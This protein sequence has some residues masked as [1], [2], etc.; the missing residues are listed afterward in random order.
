[1]T[2]IA[3]PFADDNAAVPDTPEHEQLALEALEARAVPIEIA[4]AAGV[5]AV[6]DAQSEHRSFAPL[7][8]V[9]FS[10]RDPESGEPM[11]YMDNGEEKP[12]LRGRYLKPG[13]FKDWVPDAKERRYSQPKGSPV[14][15]YFATGGIIDWR[16]LFSNPATPIVIVEGEFKALAA[17]ALGIP[18]VALGG[19]HSIHN[20]DDHEFLADLRRINLQ[21]RTVI[22]CFDSDA[23]ENPQVLS[24]ERRLTRE[25]RKCGSTVKIARLEPDIAGNKVGLD[26]FIA[27]L[28]GDRDAVFRQVRDMLLNAP[29]AGAL[30]IEV[31]DRR[32]IENLE[33]L[34]EALIESELPVFQQ[35]GRVVHIVNAAEVTDTEEIKRAADSPVIREASALTIQQFG[36]HVTEFVKWNE[37]KKTYLPTVCPRSLAE[38]YL[39]KVGGWGLPGLHGIVEA[40]TIRPGG[41]ILQTPGYDA[42]SGLYYQPGIP[43]PRIPDSPSR[44]DAQAA[45]ARLRNIVRAF[46]FASGEAEATWVAAV[47]TAIVRRSLRTAPMFAISAPVMG[48]G[49]TLAAD[50]IG[51]IATGHAPAVM[52]QGRNPDEDQ[53]RLLAVLLRGDSVVQIDNCDM[54]I[55]GAAMSS[56][57]TSPEWQCRILGRSENVTVPTNVTFLATGNNITLRADMSTRALICRIAPKVERPEERVFDFDARKEAHENRAALV[58]AALVII[59]AYIAAGEPKQKAKTF[60][61]FEDWDRYVRYPLLWLDAPDPCRTRELIERNDPERETF[62]RLVHLWNTVFGSAPVRAKAIG[63][64]QANGS[65][66]PPECRELYDL[67][68][69]ISGGRGRDVYDAR[70]FGEYLASKMERLCGGYRLVKGTDRKSK[71][72]LWQLVREE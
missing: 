55:E 20:S 58:A 57:L 5:Y 39:V 8:A 31:S 9:I 69:E 15:A 51:I 72:S 6:L 49:K 23:T 61:R 63:A 41:T 12:V 10:Y 56:I 65:A 37:R 24:A 18:A 13:A 34:D 38:H 22:I 50:L 30:A 21:G 29:E 45:I 35:A 40:P 19:V 42:K 66:A 27:S 26:D 48:A 53:K 7:P 36:M 47:L 54:P 70:R 67:A 43:F 64:L 2:D 60:G 52:S 44:E 25:L 11:T 62:G 68:C 4:K 33:E 16:A 71:T 28:P 3:P 46:E 14:R 17:C 59:R 32:L 1:M